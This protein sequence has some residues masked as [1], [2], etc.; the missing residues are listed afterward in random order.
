MGGKGVF[1]QAVRHAGL[2]AG[3]AWYSTISQ[4]PQATWPLF[5]LH[6]LLGCS[7]GPPACMFQRYEDGALSPNT[8]ARE[9]LLG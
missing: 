3:W 1:G 4:N 9:V 7:A 6:S 5:G 2:G 8:A